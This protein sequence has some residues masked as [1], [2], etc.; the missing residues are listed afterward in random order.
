M[1]GTSS[2]VSAVKIL[3]NE[4]VKDER[5]QTLIS[6]FQQ[7]VQNFQNFWS[8]LKGSEFVKAQEETDIVRWTFQDGTVLEVKQEE[9]SVSFLIA[10]LLPRVCIRKT[11][12]RLIHY[13][14][15]Q[16]LHYLQR[17]YLPA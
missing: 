11:A 9:H 15:H 12:R 10:G 14:D 17:H 3:F 2:S 7:T 5:E 4:W 16:P 1:F 13:S 6:K 8:A